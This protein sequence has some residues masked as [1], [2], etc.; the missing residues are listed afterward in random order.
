MHVMLAGLH[1]MDMLLRSAVTQ[2]SILTVFIALA[3]AGSTTFRGEVVKAP[4][5]NNGVKPRKAEAGFLCFVAADA[6]RK[7]GIPILF[8]VVIQTDAAVAD[9][10]ELDVNG[11]CLWRA[12]AATW[13]GQ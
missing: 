1:P 8:V 2:L 4:A 5:T 9:G 7:A 12:A 6:A 10:A 11:V 13:A 3:V